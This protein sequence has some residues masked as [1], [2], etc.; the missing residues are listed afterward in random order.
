MDEFAL[1][2]AE[3]PAAADRATRWL[4]ESSAIRARLPLAQA[5]AG[6]TGKQSVKALQQRAADLLGEIIGADLADG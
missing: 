3:N 5:Q 2:A 4:Q 1:K 6:R